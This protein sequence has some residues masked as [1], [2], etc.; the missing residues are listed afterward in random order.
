MLGGPVGLGTVLSAV[1]IGPLVQFF[2]PRVTVSLEAP[3]EREVV[4]S[5]V[6]TA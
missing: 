6:T 5:P 4:A 3:P 1:T 2:L